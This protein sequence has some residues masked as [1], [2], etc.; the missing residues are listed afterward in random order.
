MLFNQ[1]ERDVTAAFIQEPHP[2]VKPA[3]ELTDLEAAK[4]KSA[5]RK[6]EQMTKEEKKREKEKKLEEEIWPTT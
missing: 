2:E 4:K 1:V 6:K 5:E 3:K